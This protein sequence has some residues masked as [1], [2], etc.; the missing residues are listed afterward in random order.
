MLFAILQPRSARAVAVNA[1]VVRVSFALRSMELP[2]GGLQAVS[3]KHHRH[4][5]SV[6]LRHAGGRATVSG[7]ARDDADALGDSLESA[8]T[9]WWRRALAPQIGMLRSIHDCLLQLA[10][11][12]NYVR[13]ADIR[14][15]TRDAQAVAGGLV[16]RWPPSLSDTP[17]IRM[18]SDILDF[19]ESPNRAREKANKARI[20]NELIRSRT[21][22]DTIE[23]MPLTEEQRHAVVLDD[24]RN[25]VVA[26]AGSGKTSVIVA[27]AGWLIKR[28]YRRP[29]ELLLLAFARDARHEMQQRIRK[30]LGAAAARDV[31]VRTFH[32]LGLAIIG[33]AEGKRPTLAP[34][35][36]SDRAL[37][38]LLKG[39]VADLLADGGLSGTLLAWF[40]DQFA[41]YKSEHEFRNWG[42][43]W[44]YIRRHDVR[45][46]KGEKVKSYEECEIANYLYL[47]GIAYEYEAAYEH[48][49]ATPD[50]RQYHPD[51]HLPE[52]RIYI[53][54]F[55]L[56]AEGRT[57]SF[58]DNDKYH[59]EMEWK[60]GVHEEHGTVLIETFSHEHA[61]GNLLRNLAK[62][63]GAHDVVLSPIP[64][65]DLFG[66]LEQQGRIDPFTRLLATFLQHFKGARLSFAEVSQRAASLADRKRAEAFLAVFR[67][68]FERYQESLTRAGT[69]DFH[70]MINRATDLVESG[71]YRSPFGYIM[72]DE[73]QDISPARAR[74]LKALLDSAPDAQLFAVGD[75][76]QAI[77]RFGGSDIAVMREFETWFGEYL[78]IDL[79]TMFRTDDRIAKLATDFVLRNPAQI[80]KT[81]RPMRKSDRPAVHLGLPE[82]KGPSLLMEA[83]DRIA[84]D[85]GRHDGTASVLLLGRYR[86]LRPRNMG[87]L[88]Q[89]YPGLRLAY[90][91]VHRSKGLEA[92]YAVVLGLCSGKHGFPSEIT[93]DP[94]LDLVLAAPEAH[95]NAEERRL[96]YVAITRARRQVYLLAEG[97]PPSSFAREL[98]HG[99][100]DVN[101]FGRLPQA[102]VACPQC[103]EGRLE[104]RENPRSGGTFYG[105]SN[106]PYCSLTRPPCPSCGVGLAVRAGD[107]QRCR[108]CGEILETC[109][110]CD[111]WM[112]TRM[113]KYGRF[114]GCSNWPDCGYTRDLRQSG[115]GYENRPRIRVHGRDR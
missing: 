93:D 45:S 92:D 7:L 112:E 47:N 26:A 44:N 28:G 73:F 71:R 60:R 57:A 50:K 53:E 77:Y 84:E 114:L 62:K 86:H 49:T 32:S 58:V 100:Y 42:E 113:G 96:L 104:R 1:N 75:D 69:I 78:R 90:R 8:R 106:W 38:E 82:Q 64:R 105:C 36:E 54:H 97:G 40:R 102:D 108:D 11:P 33:Q 25:L 59:L 70:D 91:T 3:V 31:T 72:V 63:L 111:G 24:H 95:P 4:W 41:P 17:E 34:S 83:L 107:D 89:R 29:S 16:G 101:V 14:D 61:D 2:I 18:L 21:L 115:E 19:L 48:D 22:F 56:D 74:L 85:A 12:P 65:D 9:H 103:K 52:H 80:R 35:A 10:D 109:P 98:L 30:R 81:V 68:V 55:G 20:T 94:L 13:I 110:D 39:I 27:K 67:P 87:R 99:R 51:F 88:A 15:L 23:A 5:A 46:L 79:E 37:F 43:Y 76:W 6:S 66:V